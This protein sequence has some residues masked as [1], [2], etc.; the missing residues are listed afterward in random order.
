MALTVVIL[1]AGQ[2][3]RMNSDR[4]KVLQPLGGRPL[5]AHVLDTARALGAEAI[6]VVYGHG[7]EEVRAAFPDSDVGWTLQA[8][9]LGTGHAVAQALPSIPPDHAVLV[10][11][12]DAPLVATK[13][14]ESLVASA[15]ANAIGLLTAHL[16]DP[17]GYGRIL[18]DASGKITG[19]VEE[20]DA[21]AAQREIGEINTGVMVLPARWLAEALARIGN[22]N[23][24][25]EY[26]LTD[27]VQKA[28]ERGLKV[29]AVKAADSKEFFGVNTKEELAA[30]ETIIAQRSQR[31]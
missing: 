5:L 14:L 18:R 16:D 12:G 11:C 17:T 29:E 23:S 10:L 22:D 21:S 25:G 1:A 31:R 15:S 4:P 9:Q 26:Y 28:V 3:K 24:Q 8:E 13:S 6:N 30:A 20:R 2:G 7:A 19:V 27:L